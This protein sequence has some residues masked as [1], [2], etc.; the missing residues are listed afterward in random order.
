M[1]VTNLHLRGFLDKLDVIRENL[2][3]RSLT[4]R[5]EEALVLSLGYTTETAGI[6]NPIF[7]TPKRKSNKLYT[8]PKKTTKEQ[9]FEFHIIEPLTVITRRAFQYVDNVP[10]VTG[11]E[12]KESTPVN[13]LIPF[14][15]NEINSLTVITKVYAV[16]LENFSILTEMIY[17][18]IEHF[19]VLT[20]LKTSILGTLK[21]CTEI[22]KSIKQKLLVV[23]PLKTTKL[24]DRLENQSVYMDDVGEIDELE[25]LQILGDINAIR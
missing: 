3:L 1:S 11:L 22:K 13:V 19:N 24:N 7:S 17:N 6:V 14:T 12:T 18:S 15:V 9:P 2:H 20:K 25:L 16:V 23:V 5:E 4:E 8:I 21:V 10:V